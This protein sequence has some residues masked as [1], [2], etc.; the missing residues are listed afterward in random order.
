V[1]G[2]LLRIVSDVVG[3]QLNLGFVQVTVVWGNFDFVLFDRL[4]V[5]S[6]WWPTVVAGICGIVLLK[7]S[8]QKVEAV[9]FP[10][11]MR[12]EPLLKAADVGN[13][14]DRGK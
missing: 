3:F 11:V 2:F 12:K 4:F 7:L 8:K 1:A 14:N 5:I 13:D 10:I 9:G 6:I